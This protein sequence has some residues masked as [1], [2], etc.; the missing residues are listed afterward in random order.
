MR[1]VFVFPAGERAE[2]VTLLD[3]HGVRQ[4]VSWTVA[5]CLYVSVDDEQGGYLFV[6]WEVDDVA[7]VAA[8]LGYHPTWA[9]QV[10]VSGRVDGTTEVRQL[11]LL[12]LE[13]GGVAVDDY[14]AHAWTRQEVESGA[15]IDGL[16]FFDFRTYYERRRATGT[17]PD[18]PG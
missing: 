15:V 5:D 10:D 17:G 6:D 8:A 2:T 18:S 11:V 4:D 1:S 3:H 13:R 12:L 14:C 7:L 9:V 16:R